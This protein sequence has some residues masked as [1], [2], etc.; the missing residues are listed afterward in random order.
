M[1]LTFWDLLTVD[2]DAWRLAFLHWSMIIW[3]EIITDENIKEFILCMT[4]NLL[5][6]YQQRIKYL[7]ETNQRWYD[8]NTIIGKW[9]W[10]SRSREVHDAH[11]LLMLELESWSPHRCGLKVLILWGT[12]RKNCLMKIDSWSGIQ[13]LW[14]KGNNFEGWCWLVILIAF[15]ANSGRWW[16]ADIYDIG[17]MDAIF[18]H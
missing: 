16:S 13:H 4:A 1:R 15:S 18:E 8:I 2:V 12:M 14:R 10:R 9:R 17:W 7:G 11:N 6:Q 3:N 5:Y